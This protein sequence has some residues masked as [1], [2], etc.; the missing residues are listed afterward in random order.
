MAKNKKEDLELVTKSANFIMRILPS[1]GI[2]ISW[3]FF[4]VLFFV[5]IIAM[6]FNHYNMYLTAVGILKEALPDI[7]ENDIISA[8]SDVMLTTAIY[9]Y[10]RLLSMVGIV[11]YLLSR[12]LSKSI[13]QVSD[14]V[15]DITKGNLNV[16]LNP[17]AIF[18]IQ[19][20]NES[21]D[22]I[23]TSLKLAVLKVGIQKEEL[24]LGEAIKA[25]EEAEKRY[26]QLFDNAIDAILVADPVTRKLVD[27]NKAA[28]KLTGYS[29]E[30]ILSMKADDIHPKDQVKETMDKFRLQA[31]GKIK[32]IIVEI[33]TKEGKK[34]PVSISA[35]SIIISKNTYSLGI[36][37]DITTETEAERKYK[38]LFNTSPEAI[39]TLSPPS[40]KFTN[41]NPATLRMF[42]L[43][44]DKQLSSL[45]PAELS[46]KYQ[47]D[48]QLSTT[49]AKKM[50]ETAMKE[51]SNFFEWTHK[52][53]NGEN[54]SAN[55][56]L[57]RVNNDGGAYL[58]AIVRDIT[59]QKTAE[60][61]IRDTEALKHIA[62]GR[63][64]K[65]TKR[66]QMA[67][68]REKI[69]GKRENV[70]TGR[71]QI[72]GRR[73]R[74]KTGM[75]REGIAKGRKEVAGKRE[76]VAKG[77]EEVVGKRENV[78]KGREEEAT[79]RESYTKKKKE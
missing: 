67:E 54:F 68:S 77:R 42:N 73:E 51:G 3:V 72:V 41:G 40:W 12:W 24:G 75:G 61:S 78:A 64:E 17:T 9:N 22:R 7:A 56:Q 21:L 49:K 38:L 36:F 16:K 8:Y 33:L 39:M 60:K 45:H 74:I 44:N 59:G 62:K 6:T 52:R 43:Q 31:Q 10:L 69:V 1:S 11:L 57:T 29:R 53:Y 55:V 58:H 48:G 46:P 19:K 37:R 2:K 70:A 47:P 28:E 35:S 66:E 65:A 4:I 25:K 20:L 5:L 15:N 14:N 79:R 76:N 26:K 23:L 71:E 63:E 32:T 50:I 27:C 30:E 34:I 18:E 13:Q